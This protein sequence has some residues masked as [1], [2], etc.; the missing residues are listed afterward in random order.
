MADE[1][2]RVKG[3]GFNSAAGSVGGVVANQLLSPAVPG[4][5]RRL[6]MAASAPRGPTVCRGRFDQRFYAFSLLPLRLRWRFLLPE[7]GMAASED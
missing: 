3:G 6:G 2:A 5:A 1:R 4:T 7:I